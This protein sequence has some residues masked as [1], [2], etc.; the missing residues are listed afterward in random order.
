MVDGSIGMMDKAYFVGK[1][2]IIQWV[3]EL[4]SVSHTHPHYLSDSFVS[5]YVFKRLKSALPVQ[6]TALLWTVCIRA[7]S[8]SVE[9]SGKLN[10]S[11]N[12]WRTT[13]S[14]KA[15]ST[16]M[17]L[18]AISMLVNLRML[19]IRII[20][21]FVSGSRPFS[22]NTTMESLMTV[23]HVVKDRIFTTLLEV[24]KSTLCLKIAAKLRE[25][26][27]AVPLLEVAAPAPAF[28]PC[29]ERQ[30]LLLLSEAVA[31]AVAN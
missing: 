11:T 23:L 30:L 2:V 3:N 1:G 19:S 25:D 5:S 7:L 27:L 10:M 24:T 28:P 9:L 15:L 29:K 21:S 13:K 22:T 26:T 17:V 8:L 4:L 12:S 6:F 14:F 16:R 31:A 18:N 20:S